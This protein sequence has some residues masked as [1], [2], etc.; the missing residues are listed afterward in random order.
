MC[1][2]LDAAAAGLHLARALQVD[3]D[4][5]CASFS[6]VNAAAGVGGRACHCCG[7]TCA[8]EGD[9]ARK[10]L[11]RKRANWPGY[12]HW[13]AQGVTGVADLPTHIVGKL[14]MSSSA[15]V[16]TG[17]QHTCKVLPGYCR[18]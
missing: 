18:G 15:A 7:V 6:F 1:V 12:R 17:S 9:T 16:G 4:S 8:G 2:V 3:G 14:L 13:R 10:A 11:H 5:S